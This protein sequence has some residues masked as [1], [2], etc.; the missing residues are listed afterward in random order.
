MTE[1]IHGRPVRQVRRRRRRSGLVV[2]AVATLVA[3]LVALHLADSS[4]ASEPIGSAAAGLDQELAARFARAQAA[5]TADGVELTLTSGKRSKEE[6]QALVDA[7]VKKYGSTTEAHRW[8][9]PPKAS[10]HVKGLAVDVGPTAGARWLGKN[11][12]RFGLC[13]AY[14]NEVWHFEKLPKGKKTCPKMHED[15]SSGWS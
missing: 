1:Y 2:V 10:A 5:A 9:L 6:Q 12:L 4:G 11:G 15:S 13:R 7:A 14:A 8:V 3:T